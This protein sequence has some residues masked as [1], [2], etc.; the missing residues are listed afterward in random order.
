MKTY[1]LYVAGIILLVLA[2]AALIG[3]RVTLDVGYLLV[4]GACMLLAIVYTISGVVRE[5]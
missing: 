1:T 3:Y 4:C 5:D 2:I